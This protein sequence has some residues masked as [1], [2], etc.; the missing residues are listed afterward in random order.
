MSTILN[1][2]HYMKVGNR[3]PVLRRELLDVDSQPVDLSQAT[4]VLFYMWFEFGPKTQRVNQE[5][6]DE[7]PNTFVKVNGKPAVVEADNVTARYEW[8]AADVDEAG[9]FV[10][11]FTA[12]FPGGLELSFP[13][14]G[15]IPIYF[16]DPVGEL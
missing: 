3:L 12:F 9:S 2:A 1:P 7:I 5:R 8:E 10:G 14:R 6:A 4:Q 13:D 11:M 15:W 16:T